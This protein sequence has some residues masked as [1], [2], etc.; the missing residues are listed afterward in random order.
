MKLA[1]GTL[2]LAQQRLHNVF[3]LICRAFLASKT[4]Q[5]D[6]ENPVGNLEVYANLC[7]PL[8]QREKR[9]PRPTKDESLIRTRV[10]VLGLTV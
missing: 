4:E 5:A 6:L 1:Y 7:S 8:R 10:K 2:Y 3:K 9:R